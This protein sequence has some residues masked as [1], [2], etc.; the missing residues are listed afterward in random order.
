MFRRTARKLIIGKGLPL[1]SI[2]QP[3]VRK[4]V[5]N[6][7]AIW[8]NTYQED[9]GLEKLVR[10]ILATSQFLFPG[11]YVKHL[12]WRKGALAQDF[13]IE[14]FV[15]LKTAFPLLMLY[16]GWAD[17]AW[18]LWLV[19][20]LMLET[21]IYIPTLIFA[22]D[23]FSNPRSYRRSKI[24]IFI[25]YLEVV[26]SFAVIYAAGSYLNAP[27]RHWFDPLY[28]SF[29]STSTIG[30]GDLF[31]ITP[32]GKVL[33]SLQSSFYLSYIVLFI[34]FFRKGKEP[35]YFGEKQA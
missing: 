25:N 20:Y 1:D 11:M 10:L 21:L 15:L 19:F 31:P 28:F 27:F 14:V 3:T 17:R 34:D 13:A 29:M 32:T 33:V 24:M 7:A 18:V 6:V 9:A 12:F 35:G 2:K 30:Y 5:E 26:F 8:N 22:S 4:R 23:N 16:F